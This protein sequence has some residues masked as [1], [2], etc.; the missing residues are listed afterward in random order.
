MDL[1]A[2]A[3]DLRDSWWPAVLL[4]VLAVGLLALG[5]RRRRRGRRPALPFAAAAVVLVVAG[6]TAAGAWTGSVPSARAAKTVASDEVPGTDGAVTQVQVPL[7][8]GSGLEPSDTWIYTPPGY[9]GSAGGQ[10]GPRY[11][12][13]YLFHGEPGSS[14]DWFTAGDVARTADEL[15]RER[16]IPPVILVAPDLTAPDTDDTE[17]LDSTRPG[18]PQVETHIL[19]VVSYVDAHY[20]TQADPEHRIAAGM[21]MGAFC[22]VDQGLRHQDVYG[23]I[24]GLEAYAGPGQGGRD[25]LTSEAQFRAVSPRFYLPQLEMTRRTPVYLDT[26]EDGDPISARATQTLVTELRAK[27]LP[28]QH[29]IEA[30]QEHDWDFAGI[31]I[32]HG[33][34]WTFDQLGL[35]PVPSAQPPQDGSSVPATS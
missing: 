3:V 16:L 1:Q 32:A 15:I 13:V 11:P 27:G 34:V 31:G 30:D 5:A 35:A 6:A 14:A 4:G 7:R 28:F 17:C 29:H 20:A 19:D 22:A 12:V 18:G 26:A 24:I 8:P 25:A 33:L 21:S 10:G 23:A 2:L 9:A